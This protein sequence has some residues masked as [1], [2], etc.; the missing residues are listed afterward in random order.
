MPHAIGFVLWRQL[1]AQNDRLNAL[2][3]IGV[4]PVLTRL[5]CVGGDTPIDITSHI[6]VAGAY[7]V[8]RSKDGERL[9]LNMWLDMTTESGPNG[10]V[11]VGAVFAEHAFTRLFA[12][13]GDRRVASLDVEG[14]EPP[15]PP[16]EYDW[17]PPHQVLGT[18]DAEEWLDTRFH[19]SPTP[20]VFG[21]DHTDSNQHVNS[22]VYP[23]LFIDAALRRLAQ[24]QLDT[25]VLARELQ[26]AFR[27]PAFA[28]EKLDVHVRLFRRGE[29][30]GAIG[31]FAPTDLEERER[32]HCFLKLLFR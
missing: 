26:V 4:F 27:K 18:D 11:D 25:K 5:V 21:L 17:S 19:V 13:P 6:D 32:A 8:A 24:H 3:K 1:V 23:R 29:H 14:L 28:G 15:P 20:A 30:V 10:R 9:F 22:L 2:R 12:K 31:Y 7:D 16:T